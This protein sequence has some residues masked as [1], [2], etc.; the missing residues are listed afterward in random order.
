MPALLTPQQ[1]HVARLA[2]DKATCPTDRKWSA[3][4]V[5]AQ[6]ALLT[7]NT[8]EEL[9]HWDEVANGDGPLTLDRIQESGNGFAGWPLDAL[10][11]LDRVWRAGEGRTAV[12]GLLGG[13]TGQ[14]DEGADKV[15]DPY[16]GVDRRSAFTVA[17]DYKTIIFL[18]ACLGPLLTVAIFFL[19][20]RGD[21][22]QNS[23][24]DIRRDAQIAD[25]RQEIAGL[26]LSASKFERAHALYCSGMRRDSS[27]V[28][29]ADC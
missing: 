8:P 28:P 20:L 22:R 18:A 11:A 29:D 25:L 6:I 3:G 15:P 12:E 27:R 7:G 24:D 14:P 5:L 2:L 9:R 23:V 13:S 4:G 10:E 16:T 1:Q 26:N 21:L 17:V 19:Q